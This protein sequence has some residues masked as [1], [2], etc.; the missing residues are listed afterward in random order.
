MLLACVVSIIAAAASLSGLAPGAEAAES[1]QITGKVTNAATEAPLAG[2]EVCPL[3]KDGENGEEG[4]ECTTTG[5]T[6]EYTLTGVPSGEYIVVF[7]SP[8]ASG[9]N[10]VTQF[11]DGKASPTEAQTVSVLAG[12]TTS[13]IDAKLEEGGQ[14]AGRVTSAATGAAIAN[15]IVCAAADGNVESGGCALSNAGGEYAIAGLASGEYKVE[16][17]AGA[18]ALQFYDG[19]SSIAEAGTVAVLVGHTTAGIDAALQPQAA[20]PPVDVLPSTGA[21]IP[22]QTGGPAIDEPVALP[23][24]ASSKVLVLGSFAL[25]HLQCGKVACG[26]AAE[27][28]MQIAVAHGRG[29]KAEVSRET[30][31]L[32][33]G[34]YALAADKSE[35]ISLRLTAA[36]RKQFTHAKRHPV[37]AKLVLSAKGAK[38]STAS[39]LVS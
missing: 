36:G 9:L 29:A 12:A 2:I 35:T 27:L 4:E 34:T 30:V 1:G 25:V 38:T 13:G 26:G 10:Y 19:K 7:G 39:V 16:F 15:A 32:A 5:P 18:Y 14:I 17:A 37:R 20:A 21:T 28:T 3:E 31:V 22:G 6:G 11:Y 24:V 8:F 33:K 23:A